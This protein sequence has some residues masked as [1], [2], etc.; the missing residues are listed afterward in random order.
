MLAWC[1]PHLPPA[2]RSLARLSQQLYPEFVRSI[3]AASGHDVDLRQFGTILLDEG[4][5]GDFAEDCRTVD[6]SE[7]ARLEPGLKASSNGHAASIQQWPE[8]S[9]DPRAMVTA[10][11]TA[12]AV[13]GVD[14]ATETSVASITVENG[15]ATGV[16][17]E[18]EQYVGTAVVN[19]AGAWAAQV[20]SGLSVPPSPI[21]PVKGQ[22][23]AL[24]PRHE[25]LQHVVRTPNVYLIPRGDGRI[26]VGA[27]V[28]EAGFDTEVDPHTTERLRAAAVNLVPELASATVQETWAGLRPGSPD[29]LPILGETTLSGYFVATG[30]FRDGILL[31]PGTAHVMSGMVLGKDP[32]AG[33]EALSPKRFGS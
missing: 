12:C 14:V 23:L 33:F 28:E 21:R 4:A 17:T 20:A 10:L 11:I 16:E 25:L 31:A 26:V 6:V 8:W 2:A 1:D 15:R 3:Q 32:V 18:E 13:H 30:H 7:L 22:M 19:C 29:G 9:V 5:P 24:K 27:T